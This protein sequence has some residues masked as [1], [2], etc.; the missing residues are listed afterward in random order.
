MRASGARDAMRAIAVARSGAGSAA[1]PTALA[2]ATVSSAERVAASPG[3]LTPCRLAASSPSGRRKPPTSLVPSMPTTRCSGRAGS[4]VSASASASPA[5]A[6]CPPSSQ[7][8]AAGPAASTSG[9]RFRRWSRAGQ[10]AR[11]SAV[12]QAD[13]FTPSARRAARA[14]PALA[15]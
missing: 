14:A 11:V 13:S 8:S 2:A 15:T 4:R 3:M 7:S 1:M 12:S 10:T 9:P 6:L 5:A